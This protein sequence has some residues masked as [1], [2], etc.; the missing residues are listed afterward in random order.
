MHASVSADVITSSLSIPEP[1]LAVEGGY[2][3]NASWGIDINTFGLVMNKKARIPTWTTSSRPTGKKG[4][5]GFNRETN[6]IEVYNTTTDE[7]AEF[8]ANPKIT[9]SS[10]EPTSPATGD[11]WVDTS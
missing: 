5:F 6:A 1:T 8:N 4:L 9:V 7:W 3:G 11:L 10:S 2:S